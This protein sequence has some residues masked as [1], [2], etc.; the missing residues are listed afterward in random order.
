L[1]EQATRPAR[2]TRGVIVKKR[3]KVAIGISLA[4]VFAAVGSTAASAT[5]SY[6]EGGVWN[7]G[8][9]WGGGGTD[10]VYSDYFHGSRSHKASACNTGGC[11]A[12]GWINGGSWANAP[13]R[14]AGTWGNTS[15]YDVR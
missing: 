8:V 10:F 2:I 1:E 14:V 4:A 6:P 7:Y 11:N 12:T 15:Y 9:K 13:W 5:T 3:I